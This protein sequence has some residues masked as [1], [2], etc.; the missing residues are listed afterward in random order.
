M[1]YI[2]MIFCL[3]VCGMTELMLGISGIQAPLLVLGMFYFGAFKQWRFALL[4]GMSIGCIV[5]LS[6]GRAIPVCLIMMPLLTLLS[7]LWRWMGGTMGM[8][9]QS[10]PGMIVGALGGLSCMLLRMHVMGT[11]DG[12]WRMVWL[13]AAIGFVLLPLLCGIFDMVA[14]WLALG[15]YTRLSAGRHDDIFREEEIDYD[16]EFI[17]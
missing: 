3:S 2:W 14:G 12:G 5:E 4:A 10:V 9:R 15:R 1:V 13:S 8:L 7:K 11:S 16:E 17:D 6:Y